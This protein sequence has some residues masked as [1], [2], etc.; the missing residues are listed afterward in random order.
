[1][2]RPSPLSRSAGP[3]TADGGAK[4]RTGAGTLWT[5]NRCNRNNEA[6][7]NTCRHC[8]SPAPP[9]RL[10]GGNG[11]AVGGR[12]VSGNPFRR[13]IPNINSSCPSGTEGG[14]GVRARSGATW[15]KAPRLQEHAMIEDCAWETDSHIN[16]N[17]AGS[18][19]DEVFPDLHPR[20]MPKDGSYGTGG[21][22]QPRPNRLLSN[23]TVRHLMLD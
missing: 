11:S 14:D 15:T 22:G 9:P 10:G 18:M 13:Y 21:G 2:H 12:P 23:S 1:M 7:Y 8:R 6:K 19:I 16:Q 4:R 17:H 20:G 5:C 3:N